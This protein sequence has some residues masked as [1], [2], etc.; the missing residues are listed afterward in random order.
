[1]CPPAPSILCPPSPTIICPPS[2][3]LACPPAPDIIR[4]CL[5]GPDPGPFNPGIIEKVKTPVVSRVVDIQKISGIGT[6]RAALLKG[7]GIE[8][9]EHLVRATA[10]EEDIRELSKQTSISTASLRTWRTRAQLL[11]KRR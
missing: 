8:T 2:P 10:S 7:A 9:V 6:E 3:T 11:I 4:G 5:P 1:M